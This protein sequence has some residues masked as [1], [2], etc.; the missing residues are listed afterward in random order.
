MTPVVLQRVSDRL[1]ANKTL[2]FTA[3]MTAA[4]IQAMI[5]A[6]PKNLNGYSLTLQFA[7]G[8]YS[9]GAARISVTM[10]FGGYVLIYGNATDNTAS[11]TKSVV[12]TRTGASQCLYIDNPLCY[13]EIKYIDFVN[14]DSTAE[15]VKFN[16]CYSGYVRYCA[17]HSFNNTSASTWITF[18][19]QFS[20]ILDCV[21]YKGYWGIRCTIG[22]LTSYSCSS[23]AGNKP[24]YGLRADS[25]GRIAKA[26]A[27]QPSGGTAAES[28]ASGG[29]IA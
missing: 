29:S 4:Q 15:L 3:A 6:V 24:T 7:D 19:S 25:G 23:D 20:Y 11:L 8:T 10:F 18:D 2:N 12:I 13:V 22:T 9:L 21:G 1:Q 17:F 5:D 26:D 28:T 14:S 16:K 27:T